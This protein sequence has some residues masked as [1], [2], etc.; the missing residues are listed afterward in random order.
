[1]VGEEI[2]VILPTV[3]YPSD[4]K[5]EKGEDGVDDVNPFGCNA[6]EKSGVEYGHDTK[7]KGDLLAGANDTCRFPCF[8]ER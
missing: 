7:E 8:R 6:E 4:G 2:V 3:R 5:Q 1:M